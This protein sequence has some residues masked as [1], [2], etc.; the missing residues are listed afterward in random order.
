MAK[1]P[2]EMSLLLWLGLWPIRGAT[3]SAASIPV[4]AGISGNNWTVFSFT[5]LARSTESGTCSESA[6][7]TWTIQPKFFRSRSHG[8]EE[9][10]KVGQLKLHFSL[11]SGFYKLP[12][13]I[14][15]DGHGN[16]GEPWGSEDLGPRSLQNVAIY[17]QCIV[18]KS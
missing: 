4:V 17:E 12:R 7:P 10:K 14:V 1:T 6:N 18:V 5:V 13:S 3:N 9:L 15:M 16:G 8:L 2:I 11:A